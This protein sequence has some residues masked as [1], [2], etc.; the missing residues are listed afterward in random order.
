L[1]NTGKFACILLEIVEHC[2][3]SNVATDVG[4][5]PPEVLR[6]NCPN[7]QEALEDA[8][9]ARIWASGNLDNVLTNSVKLI[10]EVIKVALDLVGL[11]ADEGRPQEEQLEVAPGGVVTGAEASAAVGLV[12]VRKAVLQAGNGRE[13]YQIVW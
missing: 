7:Q 1:R 8:D 6:V 5:I 10:A 3:F 9:V 4:Y 12:V 2:N 13:S 11:G